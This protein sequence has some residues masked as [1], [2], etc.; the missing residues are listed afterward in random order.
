MAAVLGA[1]CHDDPQLVGAQG[2]LRLS[3]EAVAFPPTYVGV[4]RE[5]TVRVFNAGRAPLIVTWTQV[6]APFTVEGLPERLNTGEVEVRVRFAPS[7]PGPSSAALTGTAAGGGMVTLS[8]MG[9]GVAI[10]ACPTPVACHGTG[11]DLATEKCV[12]TQLPDGTVCDPG[13][14]CLVEATCTAGRCKG[15]ERVCDDGNACTT[16][17]CNP[18]DGCQA[19]PA[20]PCPGDGA[21]KVGVCDPATGCGLARAP[22]GTFCGERRGCEVAD[23][24][25]D[26]ACTVQ[27]LPDGFV[28]ASATPCQAEG[29]CDGPVCARPP[30]TVLVPDWTFDADA[31]ALDLHDLMIWPDGTVT[32]AGFFG[33][34]LQ[35]AAGDLPLQATDTS[36][37]CMLWNERLLC[38]DFPRQG[39]VSLLEKTTGLARWSFTLASARPDLEEKSNGTLFMARL[40]VMAPDRL[41]ALFEAYPAGQENSTLCRAYFLVVLDAKGGLVSSAHLTDPL[42]EEC[43]HPHPFGLVSDVAGDLYVTFSPTVNSGAP[44]LP[45]SPTLVLAYSSDG[46]E[47]WRRLLSI[48]GGELGLVR[49]LLLPER[50]STALRTQDGAEVGTLPVLGR[51]VATRQVV[52]PSPEGTTVNPDAGVATSSE[53]KGYTVPELAPA[54]TYRLGEG[55]SFASKELRLAETYPG[56]SEGVETLVL[57]FMANGSK[58][59]LVGVRAK[60]GSEAFQCT[61]AYTP[62][63]V[64]Q[65]FELGPESLVLMD[66]AT[67]CGECDPPFAYSRARF[68]RFPLEGLRPAEAPWPG[69][70]GGP[71]HG[72]H[73]SPVR[74]PSAP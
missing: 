32:L 62:R 18:L 19:V 5:E 45:G 42:L 61:L 27:N 56:G 69:T 53:L 49:G 2:R 63:T 3:V 20:P 31:L 73:E 72:H 9:E 33:R 55:Q 58:P 48:P 70:F 25:V 54:W 46:V 37:R 41:A 1:G 57:G 23:V 68:Q 36:R 51:A 29:R 17:V 52:V 15:R 24:C 34:P 43:N 50:A 47:R 38:M 28:C 26:G 13:N 30:P 65:L 4:T 66:G 40:A 74:G 14:A 8:L 22:D 10:P 39:Q 71:G 16:D 59:T 21:C 12:E 11:F 64:P 35:D 6:D 44:L 60:D 67:T 7:A